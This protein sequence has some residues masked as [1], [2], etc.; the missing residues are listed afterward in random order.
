M[1]KIMVMMRSVGNVVLK[2]LVTV[3]E[4]RDGSSGKRSSRVRRVV[5]V[6]WALVLVVVVVV[7]VW[8]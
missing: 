3:A 6:C 7:V 5:D 2:A 8:W 1:V 4:V